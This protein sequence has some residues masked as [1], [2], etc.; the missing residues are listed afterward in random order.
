MVGKKLS[1]CL[2]KG[3]VSL[4]FWSAPIQADLRFV[5]SPCQFDDVMDDTLKTKL[6]RFPMQQQ[7]KGPEKQWR[8]SRSWTPCVSSK[9]WIREMNSWWSSL[10]SAAVTS[11]QPLPPT[12]F[13]GLSTF[14]ALDMMGVHPTP[15]Q[16][17]S[18]EDKSAGDWLLE[19]KGHSEAWQYWPW[20]ISSAGQDNL[21]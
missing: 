19:V 21:G 10:I 5:T 16:S 18:L 1:A 14:G 17:V 6:Q 3:L 20:K 7:L 4:Q 11:M 13:R 15:V 12:V 9:A 8:N 2:V